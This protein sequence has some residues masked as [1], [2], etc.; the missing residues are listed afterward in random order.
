M[1]LLRE[2]RDHDAVL[3]RSIVLDAMSIAH[4]IQPTPDGRLGARRR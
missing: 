2:G 1:A 3:D 4:E